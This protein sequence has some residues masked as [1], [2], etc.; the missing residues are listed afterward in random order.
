[1]RSSVS[2][3]EAS[4]IAHRVLIDVGWCI[5]VPDVLAVHVHDGGDEDEQGE[6]MSVSSD[7]R[8]IGGHRTAEKRPITASALCE[9]A[10]AES[11]HCMDRREAEN[12]LR[13][14]Q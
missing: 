10:G 12:G 14:D 3:G 1:M 11:K 7:R 13:P 8:R 5:A 2:E 6:L 4:M 9:R